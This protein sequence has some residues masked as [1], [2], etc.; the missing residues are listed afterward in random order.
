LLLEVS[1]YWP[2]AQGEH[3]VL[4]VDVGCVAAKNPAPHTETAVQEVAPGAEEKVPV[5]QLVHGVEGSRST[6][7]VPAR[8]VKLAH[9]P[10]EP[11]G[12]YEPAEHGTHGVEKSPSTSEVPAGHRVHVRSVN[13]VVGTVICW[14]GLQ[15]VRL[16][17]SRSLVV[18]ATL[19]MYEVARL[20]EEMAVQ[21]RLEVAE[22]ATLAYCEAVQT[23]RLAHT[24][25]A[26]SVAAVKMY[27]VPEHVAMGEQ[28]RFEMA[29][30]A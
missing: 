3:T 27:C 23:V 25:S 13:W 5:P 19:L 12:S 10:T 16:E 14:P 1:L 20:H 29:E 22:A 4:E 21:T 2:A 6:S 24:V 7:A 30:G 26:T 28:T 17:H 11:S 9:A 8:Q 15:A 18:V